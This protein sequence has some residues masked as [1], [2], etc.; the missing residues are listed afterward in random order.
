MTRCV[1]HLE[2]PVAHFNRVPIAQ[3]TTDALDTWRKRE[4]FG[5]ECITNQRQQRAVVGM[6]VRQHHLFDR[7]F[8]NPGGSTADARQYG[9]VL[10]HIHECVDILDP[11][12]IAEYQ[13][14][15]GGIEF[16][17]VFQCHDPHS[18]TSTLRNNCPSGITRWNSEASSGGI[19]CVCSVAKRPPGANAR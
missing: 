11:A 14:H 4:H 9:R 3:Q 19:S 12:R 2:V 6:A 1:N 8:T 13:V 10:P 16:A 7:P 15:L 5:V 18:P 17:T